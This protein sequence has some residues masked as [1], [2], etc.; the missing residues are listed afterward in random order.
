[1]MHFPSPSSPP[2]RVPHS[3][4]RISHSA[5]H[6][7]FTLIELIVVISIIVILSAIAVPAIKN[8]T[9]SNDTS[10][11]ANLVRTMIAQ[12]R[13]IA[14]SQHRVAG[15]VFFEETAANSLP[16]N[17]G[18]T[19]MQL[20]VEDYNQRRM[21]PPD[22]TDAVD[23]RVSK[24]PN[25]F[26]INNQYLVV[27]SFSSERQYLPAGIKLAT[28]SDD[29]ASTKNINTGDNTT[30]NTN[31]ARAVLFDASGQLITRGGLVTPDSTTG[32]PGSYP[33]AYADWRFLNP[34]DA[35]GIPN[36]SK[37]AS[38]PGFFL[39]NKNDYDAQ[40]FV[41]DKARGDWLR[42]HADVIVVNGYTGTVIR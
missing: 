11:A 13:T 38:S 40:S 36:Y 34:V 30:V 35:V 4:F 9:K 14:I 32:T 5:Q 20:F 7:A 10:Q 2:S 17:A 22:G 39:Y 27:V 31:L 3:A 19:A 23:Y 6:S 29:V 1:M 21:L 15:V 25:V 42:Q 12:A 16:V 37:S 26:P 28:L 18:Q 8:L 41:D 24:A 33:R